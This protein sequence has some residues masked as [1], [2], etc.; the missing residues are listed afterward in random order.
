MPIYEFRC[1]AC[2]A[3]IEDLVKTGTNIHPYPCAMCGEDMD[4]MTSAVV[5]LVRGGTPKLTSTRKDKNV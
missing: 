2:N 4:R 1:R 3:V 5:G